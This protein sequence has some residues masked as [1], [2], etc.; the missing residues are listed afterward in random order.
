[1]SLVV[2]FETWRLIYVSGT[3]KSDFEPPTAGTS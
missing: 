1:V 2:F 3:S